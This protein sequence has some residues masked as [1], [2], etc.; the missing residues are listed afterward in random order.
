[1]LYGDSDKKK[2]L[3][4]FIA[5]RQ[6]MNKDPNE[7]YLQLSNLG[8]QAGCI[9]TVEDYRTRLLR[10][11]FN[12]MNQHERHYTAMKDAVLHATKLWNSLDCDKIRQEIRE[13]KERKDK[14]FR[15]NQNPQPKH[16]SDRRDKPH[17]SQTQQGGK[18]KVKTPKPKIACRG[19]VT[20]Q[21]EQSL[22]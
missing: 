6:R 8:I 22:L 7:F 10:P 4:E 1:V 19:T 13:K 18:E 3:E 9:V 15:Q 20:L 5:V 12:L 17:N 16:P 14:N 21:R 2:L 11:L